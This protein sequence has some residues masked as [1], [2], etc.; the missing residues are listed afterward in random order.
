MNLNLFTPEFIFVLL[1]LAFGKLPFVGILTTLQ[2]WP[3][4]HKLRVY[5]IEVSRE[6]TIR[7]LKSIWVVLTDAVVFTLLVC[8]GMLKLAPESISNILLTVVIFFVWVEIWFY[9]SHRWMHQNKFMWKF[10]EHHH[11]SALTQP[12]TSIS[13]SFIEKFVFYTCGWFLLPTVLS[14]FIPIS[15]YGI[16]AYFT[17]Y[18]IASP[19]AHS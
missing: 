1:W 7:E 19:S 5:D 3:S 13:F 14:W 9:W 12:L 18:Y 16:A 2:N 4:I 10:H 15:A 17:C 11:L 6:Q 8:S